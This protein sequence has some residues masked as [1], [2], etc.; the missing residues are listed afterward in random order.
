MFTL[1]GLLSSFFPVLS[2]SAVGETHTHTHTASQLRHQKRL[3]MSE[4]QLQEPELEVQHGND[5]RPGLLVT[6]SGF[7]VIKLVAPLTVLND[8]FP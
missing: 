7:S 5:T 1:K 8:F 4:F 3:F 6:Q 2:L